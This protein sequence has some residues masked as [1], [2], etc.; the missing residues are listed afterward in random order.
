[1]LGKNKPPFHM[2]AALPHGCELPLAISGLALRARGLGHLRRTWPDR[3]WAKT[4]TTDAPPPLNSPLATSSSGFPQGGGKPP[5]SFSLVSKCT[6][7]VRFLSDC[8]E[9]RPVFRLPVP[10]VARHVSVP[11][12]KIQRRRARPDGSFWAGLRA[13]P[14]PQN[15]LSSAFQARIVVRQSASRLDTGCTLGAVAPMVW[16]P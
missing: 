11:S 5:F 2:P 1:M 3:S 4:V 6:L 9:G 12:A 16:W 10:Y 13:V 15:A 14:G 8:P 7:G